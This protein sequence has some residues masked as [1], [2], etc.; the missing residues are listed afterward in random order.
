MDVHQP[1]IIHMKNSI[2]RNKKNFNLGAH[3]NPDN[4]DHAGPQ[5]Q[6]RHVGD[7]GILIIYCII[8]FLC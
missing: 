2:C 1:V 6:L 4:H 3:Y 8:E 7:L 5:D